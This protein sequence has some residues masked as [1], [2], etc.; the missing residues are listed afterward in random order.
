M[1]QPA[2]TVTIEGQQPNLS[3][4]QYWW[5]KSVR[6]YRLDVHCARCLVGPYDRRINKAMPLGQAVELQGDLVYLCGVADGRRW[7]NNFHAAAAFEEGESF[8]LPTYNGLDVRFDNARMITIEPLPD[9]WNGLDKSFTT[10][11]NYQFAL[12][13]ADR[14]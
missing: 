1:A 3:G 2:I 10:C 6:G 12:Q 4:F 11:R 13:M 7:A 8:S 14:G 5:L 9:G